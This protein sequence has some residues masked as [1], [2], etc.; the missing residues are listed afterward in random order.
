MHCKTKSEQHYIIYNAFTTKSF[1]CYVM[2]IQLIS[3]YFTTD[4]STGLVL[5][6]SHAK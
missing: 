5:Q 6:A 4:L 1:A 3:D 2:A